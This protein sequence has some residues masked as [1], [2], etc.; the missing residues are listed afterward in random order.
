MVNFNIKNI[1]DELKEFLIKYSDL[2]DERLWD[3]IYYNAG[4][5]EAPELTSEDVGHLDHVLRLLGIEVLE[6]MDNVPS[7]YMNEDSHPTTTHITLPQN[8]KHINQ[9]AFTFSNLHSINLPE[10]LESIG[11]SAFENC[12]HLSSIHLPSTLT[13]IEDDAFYDCGSLTSIT[14]NGT[15][16]MWDSI[17]IGSTIVGGLTKTWTVQCLDGKCEL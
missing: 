13:L 15:C 14:Y 10:G 4:Y 16:K 5:R 1:S 7:Y 6:E 8:I 17:D 2:I 12:M 3:A 9:Y 11:R